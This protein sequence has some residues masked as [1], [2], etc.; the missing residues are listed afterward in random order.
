MN[1]NKKS[2]K[3]CKILVVIVTLI[4]GSWCVIFSIDYY[5]C[6]HRMSPIFVKVGELNGDIKSFYGI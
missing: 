1:L 3:I 5:R 6:S 4:V 2:I